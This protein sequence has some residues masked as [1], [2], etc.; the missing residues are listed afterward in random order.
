MADPLGLHYPVHESD[1]ALL[2]VE[3]A[4]VIRDERF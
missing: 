2:T 4:L 1:T 3:G